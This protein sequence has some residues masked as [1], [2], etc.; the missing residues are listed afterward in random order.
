MSNK[1]II[2]FISCSNG[3]IVL[4]SKDD[5]SVASSDPSII[6]KFIKKYGIAQDAYMSSSMDFASEYGFK[7]NSGAKKLYEKARI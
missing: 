4:H 1:K 6:R 2:D 5:T 3:E 7:N